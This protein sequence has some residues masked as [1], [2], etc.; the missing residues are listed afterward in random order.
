MHTYTNIISINQ[1]I[2]RYMCVYLSFM[3]E[4]SI[5]SLIVVIPIKWFVRW[6][7]NTELHQQVTCSPMQS[8]ALDWYDYD[9]WTQS[10]FGS[11][12]NKHP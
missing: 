8:L 2:G 6:K 1:W 5:K 7:N 11:T 4:S 3:K 10:E 9:D 12:I